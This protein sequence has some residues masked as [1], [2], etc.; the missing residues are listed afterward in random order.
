MC[1]R[2]R[3]QCWIFLRYYS[4]LKCILTIFPRKLVLPN[5]SQFSIFN[6]STWLMEVYSYMKQFLISVRYLKHFSKSLANSYN[7]VRSLS[8]LQEY[9]KIYCINV[10]KK[11]ITISKIRLISE[12]FYNVT[13][14][15]LLQIN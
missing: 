7:L 6:Y 15:T 1:I 12:R 14:F 8:F 11:I 13:F 2:D 3:N 4:L 5:S 9:R 10:S